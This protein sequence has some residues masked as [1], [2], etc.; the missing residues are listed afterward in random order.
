MRWSTRSCLHPLGPDSVFAATLTD[1][2]R[3]LGEMPR[4][5]L[6]LIHV[7]I[8]ATFFPTATVL[9]G[10]QDDHAEVSATSA[11]IAALLREHCRRLEDEASDDP[12]LEEAGLVEAWRELARCRR[13]S[14]TAVS[15]RSS[16]S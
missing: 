5:A 4:G 10:T 16:R 8:A 1:L 11:R 9:T 2:R 15:A 14:R 13:P 6:A 12:D 3:D 7:A